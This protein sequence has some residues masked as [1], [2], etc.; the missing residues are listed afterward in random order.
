MKFALKEINIQSQ[1]NLTAP[2]HSFYSP[3]IVSITLLQYNSVI[4]KLE[5]VKYV[6]LLTL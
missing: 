1:H 5:G 4:S 2:Q 3:K 6:I